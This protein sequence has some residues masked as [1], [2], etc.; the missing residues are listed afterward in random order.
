MTIKTARKSPVVA[1][2]VRPIMI[3]GTWL[4]GGAASNCT[5]QTGRHITSVNYNAAAG[6]YIITFASV[7]EVFLGCWLSVQGAAG[8]ATSFIARPTVYS[9][10]AGTLTIDVTDLATP[11]NHDLATTEVLHI[12][13][14]WDDSDAA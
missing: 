6:R 7:G 8:A 13:A 10:S 2:A 11:T 9:A 3:A 4:G 5:R 12:L 1:T 14:L